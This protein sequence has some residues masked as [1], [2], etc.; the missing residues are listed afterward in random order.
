MAGYLDQ[1]GA[2]DER[3]IK[4]I[5][6]LVI[7]LVTLVV[8]GGVAFFVFHNYRQE[9]QV[10]RFLERLQAK[11]YQGAYEFWVARRDR[12]EGLPV[13]VVFAGLGSG[14]RPRGRFRL[15]NFQKPLLRQRR[16]PDGGFRQR[17]ARKALGAARESG[18]RILAASGVPGA[19][20]TAQTLRLQ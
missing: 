12:P 20:V 9:R 6:T 13:P 18:G 10:N 1:Y 4:I 7:S 8:L 14:Q 17:Q 19:T 3:R 5:K 2:G 16:D 11:D 15:Q